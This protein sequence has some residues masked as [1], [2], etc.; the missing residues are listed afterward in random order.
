MPSQLNPWI[1]SSVVT[2]A[3]RSCT[4]CPNLSSHSIISETKTLY[5]HQ[6]ATPCEPFPIGALAMLSYSTKGTR[7][8]L[9]QAKS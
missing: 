5:Y 2:A 7:R 9:W 3:R 4:S 6:I 8:T 1:F